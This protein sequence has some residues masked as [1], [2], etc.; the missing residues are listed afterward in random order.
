LI[1]PS[2]KLPKFNKPPVA[3]VVL[4]V[5]FAPLTDMHVGH[6]GLLWERFKTKF[7]RVEQQPRLPHVI[8]RKG[9]PTPPALV[10]NISIMSAADLIPRMWMLSEDSTEMIQ[11]QTD[12]FLRNWRRYHND[13]IPYPSYETSGR[14][15][16]EGDYWNFCEFTK[17]QE[18][19][20]PV[21]DQ[22]EM[23]YINH[24][25]P[26]GVWSEFAELGK[27]FNGWASSYPVLA[28]SKPDSIACRVRHEVADDNGQY[29][30]HLFVESDSGYLPGPDNELMPVIQFQLIVRGRPLGEGMLGVMQFM[31]LAHATIVKSFAEVT[32]PE[33]HKVWERI[34]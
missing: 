19:G 21:I 8:E 9:N 24:I 28:G 15:G 10:P 23:T 22:C 16:F 7:T 4:G 17:A 32:T 13:T 33:M 30:G 20:E 5:Q 29:V 18:L 11:V 12:R 2:D 3:E 31:D 27:V 34:Q 6:I 1:Q 14:P 25:R 26:C